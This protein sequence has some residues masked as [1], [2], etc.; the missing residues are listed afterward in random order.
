MPPLGLRWI[1]SD[2]YEPQGREFDSPQGWTPARS[3]A[4]GPEGTSG[5]PPVSNLS[6]RANISIIFND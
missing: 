5:P 4:G 3:G 2:P 6:G 1:L